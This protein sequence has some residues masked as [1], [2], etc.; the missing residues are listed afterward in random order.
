[1]VFSILQLKKVIYVI[2]TRNQKDFQVNDIS[3]ITP[4]QFIEMFSR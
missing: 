4:K 2:I 3:I 1:M